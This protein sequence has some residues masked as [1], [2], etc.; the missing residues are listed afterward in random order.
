MRTPFLISLIFTIVA[1]SVYWYQSTA[2]M[3][4]VPLLYRIGELDASFELTKEEA[5]EYVLTAESVWEE[6]V[7]RE[8]FIYDESAAFTIDFV[9]DERQ[10]TAN[11][12]ENIRTTLDE[13]RAENERVQSTVIALRAEYESLDTSYRQRL[14]TYESRLEAYNTKVTTYNDRGG[15]PS[16]VFSQLETERDDLEREANALSAIALQLNELATEINR[17]ADRGNQL[18]ERYNRSVDQYNA[19]FGYTREFTQ[20]DYQ[21]DM[22]HI[23]KFSDETELIT[24]LAHE[25]GHA[26]GIDHVEGASSLMYYLLGDTSQRP[27][28]SAEDMQ[29]FTEVCG[30]TETLGQKVRRII[31]SGLVKLT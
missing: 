6:A 18:I 19:T 24:V 7:G 31:R 16:E 17:L 1:G 27:S 13:Q 23:Y 26:L 28:L 2:T 9:F 4:P 22:I 15:A 3:C 30:F 10:A 21:G 20:G 12:E 25:F 5:K 14:S 11:S 29:A 8:L